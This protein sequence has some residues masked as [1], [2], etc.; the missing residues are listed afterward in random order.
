MRGS[1]GREVVIPSSQAVP[2]TRLWDDG[3]TS[4]LCAGTQ[5]SNPQPLPEAGAPPCSTC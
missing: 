3:V 2:G 5:G 1:V 4:Q